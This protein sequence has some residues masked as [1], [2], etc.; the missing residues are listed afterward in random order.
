MTYIK[1]FGKTG[2]QNGLLV[3]IDVGFIVVGNKNKAG[4]GEQSLWNGQ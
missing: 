1:K 3:G 4:A 2:K